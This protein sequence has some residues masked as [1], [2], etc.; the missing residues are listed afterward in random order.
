VI[1]GRIKL[2]TVSSFTTIPSSINERF[3]GL[4]TALVELCAFASE[5]ERGNVLPYTS[6]QP[7]PFLHCSKPA[8]R[9]KKLNFGIIIIIIIIIMERIQQNW[10]A[11]SRSLH[12]FVIIVFARMFIIVMPTLWNT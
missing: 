7:K 12:I 6:V 8:P 1:A 3:P 2:H 10:N 11:S 5:K 9:V 4:I